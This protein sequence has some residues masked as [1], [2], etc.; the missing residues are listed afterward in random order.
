MFDL[1]PW[2]P[3]I[4]APLVIV[5][6][7]ILVLTAGRRVRFE[8]DDDALKVRGDLYGRTIPRSDLR[9]AEASVIDMK[10]HP[11]FG[12]MLR[13]NGIGLPNYLSGWFRPKGGGRALLFVTDR[14]RVVAVP[15]TAGYELLLSPADPDGFVAALRRQNE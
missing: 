12:R 13:T 9:V 10:G 7:L 2:L 6:V 3:L 4:L 14:T 1:I 8:L 15:T 5:P 11:T